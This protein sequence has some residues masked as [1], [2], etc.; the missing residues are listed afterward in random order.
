MCATR[1]EWR[2]DVLPGF[3]LPIRDLL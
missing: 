1:Q 2:Y 3:I